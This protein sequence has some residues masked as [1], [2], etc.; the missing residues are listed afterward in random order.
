[1]LSILYCAEV[2]DRRD[3]STNVNYDPGLLRTKDF[4]KPNMVIPA[5]WEPSCFSG[6]GWPTHLYHKSVNDVFLGVEPVLHL[7]LA[8]DRREVEL[9]QVPGEQ[10]VHHWNVLLLHWS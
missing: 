1:M 8:H 5:L 6:I 4:R 3:L 7:L 9:L 2:G 10:L